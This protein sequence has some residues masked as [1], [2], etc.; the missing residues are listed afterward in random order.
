MERTVQTQPTIMR[1]FNITMTDVGKPMSA[2]VVK[3]FNDLDSYKKFCVQFGWVF[4]EKDLYN[5]NSKSWT[6][7]SAF[8]EGKRVPNNCVK[9]QK[10]KARH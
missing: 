9:D 8:K 2:N 5:K 10:R 7:F 3:L 1:E 4:N 6:S